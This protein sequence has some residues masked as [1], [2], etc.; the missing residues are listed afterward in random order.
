MWANGLRKML[1]MVTNL[2]KTSRQEAE[3]VWPKNFPMKSQ[4]KEIEMSHFL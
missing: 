1:Q 4:Q 3:F 2:P